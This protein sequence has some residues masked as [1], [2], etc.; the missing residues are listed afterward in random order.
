MCDSHNN[1]HWNTENQCVLVFLAIWKKLSGIL[2]NQ[3]KVSD[4]IDDKKNNK[5]WIVKA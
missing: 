1:P 3:K 5:P 2:A 4:I